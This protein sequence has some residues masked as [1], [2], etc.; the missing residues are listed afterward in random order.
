MKVLVTLEARFYRTADGAVWTSSALPYEFWRRY[1][2]VFDGVK[3]ATRV[4]EVPSRGP[5]WLRVDGEGVAVASTP[6]Y[7]GPW[8]YLLRARQVHRAVRNALDPTDAV[9]MRVGSQIA[10]CLEPLVVKTGH[11][12]GLEVLGDPHEVFAPGVVRH[13]LR[14]FFRWWFTRCLKRQCSMADAVAYVTEHTLQERYPSRA[15]S[16][17]IS[18]VDLPPEALGSR[19]VPLTTHYSSVELTEASFRTRDRSDGGRSGALTVVTVASLARLYKGP[20][21]LIDAVAKCVRDGMDLQLVLIGDGKYRSKLEVRAARIGLG[22]RVRSLGELPAGEAVRAHLDQADLFL[23]PS[24]TEGL[25]RAMVEAMARG[26]PC[27]GTTVGGIPEL[28]PAEDLVPSNDVPALAAKIN[29]VM[30]D[31]RRMAAMAQRNF[32]KAQEFRDEL[33]RERRTD[34]YRFV[35]QTT[36]Q[37]LSQGRGATPVSQ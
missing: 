2:S 22:G 37:W 36:E 19:L 17:G 27:I 21:V 31:P 14:P 7:L 11:P 9:I 20:D 8:Q 13:S 4:L 32:T 29:E 6:Y 10:S 33:L 28:L 25:P 12:Y 3:I 30:S 15:H 5:G 23:L 35:R 34:F 26:L 18:D 24:R 1:L 16:V